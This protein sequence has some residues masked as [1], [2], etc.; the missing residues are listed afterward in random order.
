M[1]L[2]DCWQV[3]LLDFVPPGHEHIY[4]AHT[5]IA[6]EEEANGFAQLLR[7]L[8]VRWGGRVG[9]LGYRG[10]NR[11]WGGFGWSRF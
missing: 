2:T 9:D 11:G 6:T 1:F 7:R 5:L 3:W 4:S 8:M 10:V